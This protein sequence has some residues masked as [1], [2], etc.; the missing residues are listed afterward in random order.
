MHIETVRRRLVD[1]PSPLP[2]PRPE[3]DARILR[4]GPMPPGAR[5]PSDGPV[6]DAAALVLLYLAST[7]YHSFQHPRVKAVFRLIDHIAIYLLIAGTYTPFLLV[8]LRGPWGWSIFGVIWGLTLVGIFFKIVFRHRFPGTA[9]TASEVMLRVIGLRSLRPNT[10][11][12]ASVNDG[13]PG[14]GASIGVSA[15][16]GRQ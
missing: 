11:Q 15:E 7:L 10:L 6:R 2:P 3:I 1:L 5:R 8:K 14:S 9:A 13:E 12:A 4:Q 16:L